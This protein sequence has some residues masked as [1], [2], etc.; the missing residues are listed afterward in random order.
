MVYI[1]VRGRIWLEAEAMNMVESVGNYVKHRKVPIIVKKEDRYVTFFVPAISGESIAHGYQQVLA[2]QL[3]RDGDKVC[4]LCSKGIF[5]KSTNSEVYEYSTGKTPPQK[6]KEESKEQTIKK[7][8]EIEE[9]IIQSCG[10]E[11]IGGFLYAEEV[12]VKRTSSF[13]TGYMIPVREV[14]E[15]TTVDPQ[16]HSRYALGTMFV[17]EEKKDE[18]KVKASGQTIYYVEVGSSVFTF[19]FDIDTSTIGKYT[20]ITE[21][22]GEPVPNVDPLKRSKSALRALERFLFDFPVGAK[23]TRFN[24]SDIRWESIGLAVSDDVF[25]LPSSFTKDYLSRA[26]SK[27]MEYSKNTKIYAYSEMGCDQQRVVCLPT[28]ENTIKEAVNDAINRLEQQNK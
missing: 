5:L 4:P 14:V 26:I 15:L 9:T 21:K 23:R 17:S 18:N 25:T 13:Y 6:S 16:L 2:Q 7:A 19:S 20:F 1:S 28:P 8:Q 22:Y 27:M 10:V 3:L 24:P 12:N 11:D